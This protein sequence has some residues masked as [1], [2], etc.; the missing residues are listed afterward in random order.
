[1]SKNVTVIPPKTG[2][3][4][5]LVKT[6]GK[7]AL[8]RLNP[9]QVIAEY[10]D[11]KRKV[12]EEETKREEIWAKRDVALATLSAQKELIEKYFKERFAERAAGLDNFF[13]LLDS[14]IES[15]SEKQVELALAGILGILKDSPLKDFE[16]FRES[17]Q[18]ENFLI[19]I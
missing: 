3:F 17:F 12:A 6:G 4:G 19:E 2:G 13:D 1:M 15:K 10:L 7:A 14:A 9:T 16:I 5:E 18:N 8:M 11:Y